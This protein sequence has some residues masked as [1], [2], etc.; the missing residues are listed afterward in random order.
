MS[1][2]FISHASEDHE[3]VKQKILSPLQANGIDTWYCTDDIK[4]SDEFNRKIVS[5]LDDCGWFVVAIS[6]HA[7]ESRWVAA[8]IERALKHKRGRIVPVLLE[9]CDYGKLSLPLT[10]IQHVDLTKNVEFGQAKLIEQLGQGAPSLTKPD[11]FDTYLGVTILLVATAL[12]GLIVWHFWSPQFSLFGNSIN[13]SIQTSAAN[14]NSSNVNQATN[15]GTMPTG[16]LT[17]RKE[18]IK[19]SDVQANNQN[20]N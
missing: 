2:V 16:R 12:V 5:A 18:R 4:T 6:S 9:R 17:P 7:I 19:P 10:L 11:G 20:S 8:E 14:A 15:S 1:H 13:S 3:E